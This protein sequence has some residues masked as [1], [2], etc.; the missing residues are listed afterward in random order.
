[1]DI[2]YQGS[3]SIDVSAKTV[4][5]FCFLDYC[6][7]NYRPMVELGNGVVSDMKILMPDMADL[8]QRK[9][10]QIGFNVYFDMDQFG[11]SVKTETGLIVSVMDVSRKIEGTRLEIF[12][13]D[14]MSENKYLTESFNLAYDFLNAFIYTLSKADKKEWDYIK[15]GKIKVPEMRF[16]DFHDSGLERIVRRKVA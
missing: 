7:N 12:K 13:Y 14:M 11:P 16:P 5:V 10:A 8:E 15:V 9:K 1:M 6:Y 4:S 3:E 2:L